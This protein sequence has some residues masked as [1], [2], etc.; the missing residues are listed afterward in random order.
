MSNRLDEEWWVE[1]KGGES[2]KTEGRISISQLKHSLDIQEVLDKASEGAWDRLPVP[3]H[4]PEWV[5]CR[6]PFHI[7]E[8]ASASITFDSKNPY[9]F[10]HSCDMGGDI[11]G[12]LTSFLGLTVKDAMKW[13]IEEFDLGD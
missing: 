10:C 2:P 1:V 8:H 5:P 4:K 11:V 9:F 13:L 12:I 7:D 6:C 3:P